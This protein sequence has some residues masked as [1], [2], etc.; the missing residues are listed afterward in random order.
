[1]ETDKSKIRRPINK[2]SIKEGDPGVQGP[3][4]TVAV[5]GGKVTPVAP[6]PPAP[7]PPKNTGPSRIE[8]AAKHVGAV[9][10]AHFPGVKFMAGAGQDIGNS[11]KDPNG[12]VHK[13]GQAVEKAPLAAWDWLT[14]PQP[15]P[16]D[17]KGMKKAPISPPGTGPGTPLLSNKG[18]SVD[19]I[20]MDATMM[21]QY[22][23][24]SRAALKAG[25]G[26]LQDGTHM[27]IGGQMMNM[28]SGGFGS[29]FTGQPTMYPVQQSAGSD[30]F[31]DTASL[32]KQR[33]QIQSNMDAYFSKNP[34]SSTDLGANFAS[35]S[36]QSGNRS[37]LREINETI[38]GRDKIQG[39]LMEAMTSAKGTTDAAGIRAQG[40]VA[41]AMVGRGGKA[42]D[43]AAG[44]VKAMDVLAKLRATEGL[45][46]DLRAL[47]DAELPDY[48]S[49]V[50][51]L[52]GVSANKL[53]R[54]A[55]VD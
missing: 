33:D 43:P 38:R 46:D 16:G 1:M 55:D 27:P 34:L 14:A 17:G 51:S 25:N 6:P 15:G 20:D 5:S 31:G 23:G 42:E 53:G 22:F 13:I 12:P 32:I 37:Q 52:Y 35:I 47:I 18:F 21:D 40:D 50:N 49:S 29:N 3:T 44:Q 9:A 26:V 41:Q 10:G 48:F 45:P 8:K 19:G 54:K 4:P 28:G 11:I 30:I 2:H 24:K 36:S 39:G 7:T